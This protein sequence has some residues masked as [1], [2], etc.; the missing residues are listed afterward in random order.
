MGEDSIQER[1]RRKTYNT[2]GGI[3]RLIGM[4]LEKDE[5][6]ERTKGWAFFLSWVPFLIFA[7][8]CE[9]EIIIVA[10]RSW[11]LY[12]SLLSFF[13]LLGVRWEERRRMRDVKPPCHFI[14]NGLCAPT[15][16]SQ[17]PIYVIL[18]VYLDVR[19]WLFRLGFDLALM[20]SQ[21]ALPFYYFRVPLSRGNL[22]SFY[23]RKVQK[24]I[25]FSLIYG[26]M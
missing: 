17:E 13:E 3:L 24:G 10:P 21:Y 6:T 12:L 15:H 7:C 23:S 4:S 5:Q 20:A 9:W 14:I 8:S 22:T 19:I 2:T 16:H 25:D 18:I 26:I 1:D 11:C